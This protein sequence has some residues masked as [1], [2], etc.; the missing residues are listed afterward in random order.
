MSSLQIEG[1]EILGKLGEGGMATVWKARQVSLD[2]IV[3]IKLLSQRI[4]SDPE[5][6][7]M[8]R[9]EAQAAAKLKH[10]GIVQVYDASFS[11]GKY[12]FVMEYVAGY[13]VGEWIRRK[14]VV[15]EKEALLVVE[16]VADALRYAW[17]KERMVHCDVKPDNVMIDSDGTVKVTDLGLARTLRAMGASDASEDEIM[18]TPAYISPEQA[19]GEPDVDCRADIY[20]LGAM[21]YHLL[22]GKLLF[23]GRSEEET[24]DEQI[25]GQA[26]DALDLNPRLSR[27]VCC[28][29]EKMLAK[30]REARQAD[31]DQVLADVARVKRRQNP[32]GLLPPEAVST[33]K[34]GRRRQ[35]ADTALRR[36]ARTD[37]R[38]VSFGVRAVAVIGLVLAAVFLF[39]LFSLSGGGEG[40]A[41]GRAA[42]AGVD[43]SLSALR[44]E[45]EQ[46]EQWWVDNPEA[47][48]QA[49]GR[50]QR[51]AARAQGTALEGQVRGRIREIE[52][53]RHDACDAVM[54]ELKETAYPVVADGNLEAAIKL[55][56][57]YSGRL[58]AETRDRRM[59]AARELRTVLERRRAQ[60]GQPEAAGDEE[61]QALTDAE[62]T[63]ELRRRWQTTLDLTA[64]TLLSRG[65]REAL[66]ALDEARAGNWGELDA[67]L[68]A[69]RHLLAGAVQ[70]NERILN[71]FRDSIGREISVDLVA[72]RRTL[73]VEG[74]DAHRV[75]GVQIV[76]SGGGEARIAL[77]FGVNDLAVR[78]RLSRM[79][80]DSDPELLLVRG[81]LAYDAGAL[82]RAEEFFEQ[83]PGAFAGR[84]CNRVRESRRDA[85]E[86]EARNVLG[87][88]LA[89]AGVEVGGYD[90]EAWLQ[91]VREQ[92][93]SPADAARLLPLVESYRRRF[94]DTRTLAE[95]EPILERLAGSV[96]GGIAEDEAPPE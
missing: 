82:D 80:G 35:R 92:E 84:L 67:E 48:S 3:A 57:A 60:A 79:G 77:E 39:Y 29:M 70:V 21:L 64:S 2:R 19:R 58:T 61:A 76:R 45:L 10:P 55:Y 23:E 75:S 62:R 28:L 37:E 50:L 22:T 51:V 95:A 1:F 52:L 14:R 59:H 43:P 31:W 25:A 68:D 9:R 86:Q 89:V 27:A 13:T 17:Q 8:F 20:S 74:V 66:N 91:A 30:D 56:E 16:C 24:M 46:A 12:Y 73:V 94:A 36:I 71:S 65:A 5:D 69:L 18:G 78:E 93:E 53:A 90:R 26:D 87:R 7:Q 38:S 47:Y 96:A 40:S 41:A 83:V 72:G 6:L 15:P 63:A 42:A 4:S 44:A 81:L 32:L 88:L 34:R 54:R 11:Q 33:L 85:A 49:L